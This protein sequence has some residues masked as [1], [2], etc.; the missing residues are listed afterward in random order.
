MEKETYN[1]EEKREENL[2]YILW[3]DEKIDKAKQGSKDQREDHCAGEVLIRNLVVL[4]KARDHT[5]V[6]ISIHSDA[7][8]TVSAVCEVPHPLLTFRALIHECEEVEVR[9]VRLGLPGLDQPSYV[10][11]DPGSGTALEQIGLVCV[12]TVPELL[13]S[14]PHGP[15]LVR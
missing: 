5:G 4:R 10:A 1:I 15:P 6:S 11:V 8:F 14:R 12:G 7:S 9:S 3:Y 2:L 13:W